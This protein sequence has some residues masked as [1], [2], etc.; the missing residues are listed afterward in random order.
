MQIDLYS[1]CSSSKSQTS[2]R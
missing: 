2:L 1:K